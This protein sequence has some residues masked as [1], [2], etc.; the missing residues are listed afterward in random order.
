MPTPPRRTDTVLSYR[1]LVRIR[2]RMDLPG[3]TSEFTGRIRGE[4]AEGIDGLHFREV[5]S[6]T[7]R[8]VVVRDHLGETRSMLMFGSNNYLGL[9]THPRV[10]RAVQ[11][12]V[13]AVGVGAGGPP[14]LNG[15]GPL[16]RQLEERLAAHEGKEAAL[17]FSSGYS[18]NVGLM[19][20]L[21]GPRDVVFYDEEIHASTL[22]GLKMGRIEA[23]SFPHNDARRLDTLLGEASATYQNAFVAVEGVYSMSGTVGRLDR[24]GEVTARHGATLIV[25]EAHG[26]G[27]T[28]PHGAGT[29]AMFDAGDAADVVMGTFSKA[30]GVSGGFVAADADVVDYLRYFARSYVFSTAP[31]TAIC[32]AVLA[33]LDVMEDEPEIHGQLMDVCGY[34][35]QGLR[36]RGMEAS[37]VTAVFSLPVPAGTDVRAAAHDF[38]RR[39]LFLN[40]VEA[41]AVPTSQQR[42][43]VS[44]TSDHTRDDVDRLLEAVDAVWAV[45]VA[46]VGDGRAGADPVLVRKSA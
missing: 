43:R 1:D 4:R 21:P 17:V 18:A 7:G 22:D 35:A 36:E 28:G 3:R 19:S 25:D 42:F 32:A 33:G 8:E 10:V 44:L 11:D 5:L 24:I 13:G 31:S 30:F 38:N 23:R 20:A 37:G 12:A 26:T 46:P 2:T 34:F 6:K 39:G 27:V 29:V 9:A 45:H 40:H 14:I 16:H 41:P 15:H